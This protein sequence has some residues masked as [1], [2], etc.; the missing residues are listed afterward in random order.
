MVADL[1]QNAY[2]KHVSNLGGLIAYDIGKHLHIPAFVV[3]PVV[4]DELEPVAR[5]SG[6]PELPRKSIFHALNQKAVARM[7]ADEMQTKYENTNFIVVHMGFGITIG[8]HQKGSV[9]DVNNGLNGE[10]PFSTTR[11]GSLP[12]G[13]L[14]NWCLSKGYGI[15][16]ISEQLFFRS[17]L[18]AY[19]DTDDIEIVETKIE[20]GDQYAKLIYEAMAYQI[21]KEIGAVSVALCGQ[22]DAIVLTGMLA[23]QKRLTSFIS[24]RVEWIADTL[25]YPGE[26]VMPALAAGALRILKGEEIA[27]HYK[28][29]REE[30]YGD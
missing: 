4:V 18:R 26:Y 14:M 9:I 13:D 12:V 16:E 10:G 1:K 8:A 15:N 24:R 30:Q 3:D 23:H 11:A 27:K 20:H 17:G 7:A 5:I 19:L 22:V 28:R 6:L 25:V 21:S 2:G 29:I